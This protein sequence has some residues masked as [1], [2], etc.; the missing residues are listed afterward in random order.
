M[1]WRWKR[2]L[3]VSLGLL[4]SQAPAQDF[5]RPQSQTGLPSH[6]SAVQIQRPVPLPQ[7]TPTLRTGVQMGRPIALTNP[8]TAGSAPLV[9][10]R[11]R[12]T[13]FEGQAPTTTTVR[14]KTDDSDLLNTI[15]TDSSRPATINPLFTWNKDSDELAPPPR[16]DMGSSA[17]SVAAPQAGRPPAGPVIPAVPPPYSAWNPEFE[18]GIPLTGHS[19][20]YYPG[21]EL[22]ISAEALLWWLKGD[23]TPILGTADGVNPLLGGNNQP[24]DA[25][26]GARLMAGYWFSDDH[27]FGLEAGGFVLGQQSHTQTVTSFGTTTLAIPALLTGTGNILLPIAGPGIGATGALRLQT[28]SNLNGAELN[29]R[30]NW[31]M[32]AHGFVDGLVGLR[33]VGLDEKLN[34]TAISSTQTPATGAFLE[35][36]L[37]D[38]IQTQNRFYGGQ[39]GAIAEYRLGNWVFDFT[40]KIAM[41]TTQE[42]VTISGGSLV[43]N[44]AGGS[45]IA[46]NG[47]FTNGNNIGRFTRNQYSVIPEFGTTI[48]YNFTDRLRGFV[49]YNFLY[50]SRVV[51]PG[52]QLDQTISASQLRQVTGTTANSTTGLPFAYQSGDFWAQGITL[53]LEWRY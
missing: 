25:S 51:R 2:G 52:Q 24:H 29:A 5:S 31:I 4:V 53:G 8:S 14:G 28:I 41:G 45:N 38:Q 48:G 22:Y 35:R 9:D 27:V 7:G 17:P 46:A 30:S 37:S 26:G 42:V 47:L 16:M 39:L 34:F 23:H 1:L 50:M 36:I 12:P 44:T 40:G 19:G 21:N 20:H 43:A 18:A 33:Y 13:S 11:V 3:A 10:P 49:G 32:G 6:R 15:G